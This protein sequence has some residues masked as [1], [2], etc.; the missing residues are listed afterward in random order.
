M[1]GSI[2]GSTGVLIKFEY[3]SSLLTN[4]STLLALQ[5]T[6]RDSDV[7]MAIINTLTDIHTSMPEDLL[8]NVNTLIMTHITHLFK[9]SLL[10]IS[11]VDKALSL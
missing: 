9:I 6:I 7:T 8:T 1:A 11:S 2:A 3:S 5:A 10:L 4:S